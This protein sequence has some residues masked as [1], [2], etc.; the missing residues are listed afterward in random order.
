MNSVIIVA[1]GKG[2]RMNKDINKQYIK[3]LDK[4]II[5]YTISAFDK[6]E[7]IDEII[8]VISENEKD[9]FYENILNKYNFT[10]SIKVVFGGK[11]RQDSVLSGIKALDKMCKIVLIHD[12]AR[13]FIDNNIIDSVIRETK[14]HKAV[15]VGVPVKDTIKVIDE[16]NYIKTTPERKFLWAVQTPQAFDVDI[17]KESYKKAYKDNYYGTDDSMIVERC[18]YKVKMILGSYENIKIT[19][20]EDLYIGEEILKRRR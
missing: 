3:L 7:N 10:K 14:E 16:K 1:A 13:P 19:T 18:S 20:E 4:E 17:L 5:Y 6:N 12:G 11:E 9:Y 15:V 8:V 2:K